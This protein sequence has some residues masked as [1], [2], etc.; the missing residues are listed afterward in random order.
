MI[1]PRLASHMRVAALNRLASANNDGFM[2]LRRG[3]AVAGALILIVLSRGKSPVLFEHVTG[4]DGH[5]K[6]QET[7]NQ[8]SQNQAAIDHY[9]EKRVKSDADIWLIELNIADDER[10]DLYLT[11]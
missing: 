10:L 7:L 11:V 1:E 5:I 9:C 2:V 8:S 6:W 4:F 3:D